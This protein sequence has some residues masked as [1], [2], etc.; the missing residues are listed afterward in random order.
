M[1]KE[2]NKI[3]SL[4][5]TILIAFANY[6]LVIFLLTFPTLKAAYFGNLF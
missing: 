4:S 1:D 3:I 5:A 6:F 2:I